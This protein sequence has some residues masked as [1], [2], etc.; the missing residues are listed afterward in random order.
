ML[1]LRRKGWTSREAARALGISES[2]LCLILQGKR[3]SQKLEEQLQALP[4]KVWGDP[5]APL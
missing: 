3:R 4:P 2:H 5:P 1:A